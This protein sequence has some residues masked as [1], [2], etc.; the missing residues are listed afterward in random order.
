MATSKEYKDFILEQLDLLDNIICK[1][2]MGEFLL[3]YNDVVFGGIYDNR[4]LVKI[5]D[6]CFGD[7]LI[8]ILQPHLVFDQQDDM[9]TA[10]FFGVSRFSGQMF[11]VRHGF[12]TTAFQLRDQAV[13]NLRQSCILI[14]SVIIAESK[15]FI[16]SVKH[17]CASL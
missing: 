13:K 1:A 15:R 3:Y 9:V 16:F 8:Q 10:S 2:M 14:H 4:L 11:D 12:G 17:F 7:Q 5:V 6:M